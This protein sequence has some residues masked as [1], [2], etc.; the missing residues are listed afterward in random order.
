MGL[1]EK[2]KSQPVLGAL[3]TSRNRGMQ[4]PKAEDNCWWESCAC[5]ELHKSFISRLC[6]HGLRIDIISSFVQKFRL[7]FFYMFVE[8]LKFLFMVASRR[9]GLE[10]ECLVLAALVR[11]ILLCLE[12]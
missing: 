9:P 2:E 8:L 5:K 11:R 12:S 1:R 3:H 6:C 7:E 10:P 4:K